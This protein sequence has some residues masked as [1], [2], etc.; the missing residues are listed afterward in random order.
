MTLLYMNKVL[1]I[2]SFNSEDSI[3]ETIKNIHFITKNM[4]LTTHQNQYFPTLNIYSVG[5]LV[6]PA[7]PF[8]IQGVDEKVAES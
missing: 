4:H 3:Y 5:S 6:I 8:E 1:N 2:D 7:E